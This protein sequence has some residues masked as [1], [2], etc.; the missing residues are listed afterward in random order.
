MCH[1]VTGFTC[2][3]WT[4]SSASPKGSARKK[5]GF[6]TLNTVVFAAIPK[7]SVSTTSAAYPGALR[8][9]RMVYARSCRT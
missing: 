9:V 8:I 3:T 6:I 4:S 7:A 2:V 1:P 5:Y